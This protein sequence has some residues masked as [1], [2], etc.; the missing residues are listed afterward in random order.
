MKKLFA[1]FLVKY[2]FQHQLGVTIAI[3]IFLLALCSSVVGSWQG[4]LRVRS[5]LVFNC[6][7]R[8]FYFL[9]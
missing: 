8:L 5:N 3:G 6:K 1:T 9:S 4:N 2:T 7:N